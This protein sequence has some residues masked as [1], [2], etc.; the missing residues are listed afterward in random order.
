MARKQKDRTQTVYSQVTTELEEQQV[1]ELWHRL[2]SELTRKEGGPDACSA[3]LESELTRMKEQVQ[4]ALDWV[5]K[6]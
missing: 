5:G 2:K 1:R 6:A 3:Y 4:R